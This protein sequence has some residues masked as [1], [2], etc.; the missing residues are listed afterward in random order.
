MTGMS[1]LITGASTGIGRACALDLA[2]KGFRVFATVRKEADATALRT[3]ARGL[4]PGIEVILMDVADSA[5]VAAGVERLAGLLG[6]TGLAGIVHNA[7]IG[8][9]G[10]VECVPLEG[11]RRQFEVNLFGVVG[12][13]QRCL[14]MLR[15]YA[16]GAAGPA[17]ARL[18]LVGSI[19]GRVSQPILGPYGASKF[20]LEALA[21]VLRTE[22][23]PQ[24][25]ATSILEPGAIRSEIWRKGEDSIGPVEEHPEA[26]RLYGGM[27]DA[28]R[29]AAARAA[30]GAASTDLVSRA[31]ARCLTAPRPPARVLIGRDAR[32]AALCRRWLPGS[33]TDAILRRALGIR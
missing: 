18:V 32:A 25:I 9:V 13:T 12:L 17:P 16:A 24:R 6:T 7:G 1:V 5:S 11:W 29:A 19:A 2:R 33:W 4:S 23:R 21:D 20:A 3:D 15:A 26:R 31:V 22:L 30:S 10:P 8:V 27:I 28:V 14:P